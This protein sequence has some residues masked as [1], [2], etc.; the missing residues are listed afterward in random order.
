MKFQKHAMWFQLY[1]KIPKK[2]QVTFLDIIPA[3]TQIIKT[4]RKN[5]SNN[6]H[7]SD[8]CKHSNATC[9]QY[10]GTHNTHKSSE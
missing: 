1:N 2:L 9:T 6:N 10:W 8:C 3:D 5:I 4:T 7:V